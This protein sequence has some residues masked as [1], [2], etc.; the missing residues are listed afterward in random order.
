MVIQGVIRPPPEI[1]AVADR[2]ALYVAKNG[3]AFETRILNSDKGRTPKFAFLSPSSPF[4]AYYEDKVQFYESGGEDKKEEGDGEGK[5]KK[6]EG[7]GEKTT[8]KKKKDD[9]ATA[10]AKKTGTV[11]AIDPVAKIVLSQRTKIAHL[12]AEQEKKAGKKPSD[13]NDDEGDEE[14]KLAAVVS[15]PAPPQLQF[16]NIVAPSSLGAAQIEK[17]Q[18]VA[19]LTALD[20]SNKGRLGGPA[21]SPPSS[22]SFLSQLSRREWNNPSF[23]F[24]QPRHGHFA[25]FSSLVD[26]YR[27]IIERW[28]KPPRKEKGSAGN[29]NDDDDDDS[30][31]DELANNVQKCLEVAA[32]RAEYD[33]DMDEQATKK[34]EAMAGIAQ[35]DWHDFV[36]VETIDFPVDEVVE[37]SMMPPPAAESQPP[38]SSAAA[39]T[40]AAAKATEE[41]EEEEEEDGEQIRVVPSYQPKIVSGVSTLETV[42]DP[43]TGKSIPVKDMPEHMRIQLLDPKWAEERKKFQDKQKDSNLVAGDIVASNLQRLAQA[44]ESEYATHNLL[45][46]EADPRKRLEEANRI[47]RD[48]AQQQGAVG[49]A[50]PSA[51]AKPP[52]VMAG[53]S[54]AATAGTVR[55]APSS[56]TEPVA[57]RPKIEVTTVEAPPKPGQMS[58]GGQQVSPEAA[59]EDPF[60]S[61]ATASGVTA[62]IMSTSPKETES[63]PILPEAE[64][65]ASL[66]KPEVTLHVRIPNDRAQMAWNF[67]GQTVTHTADVMSKIKSIK[68]E[69]S[70][71]HLNSMPV[72]KIQL[73]DASTKTFYNKDNM[74][75]A[76]LNLGPTATLELLPK[77]RG[78]RR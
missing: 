43:I 63:T 2:T 13:G 11:S 26:A 7:D 38:T 70:K 73:R 9:A 6:E 1:R 69:L 60:A 21:S 75:L 34:D 50:L 64:F 51:S 54:A 14:M 48:Q 77:T 8:T 68:Q 25:Y 10:K 55:P 44:R 31:I 41:E 37:V 5:K 29:S 32:Y 24:C 4:H 57:K 20:A 59:A 18:L 33:R 12:R 22:S 28:K 67:Y 42:I 74:T 78:G 36:V 62:D 71:T 47:I 49:P 27:Y 76:A 23:A 58:G 52:P 61:A 56:A 40:A 19:Q 16:V 66:E 39:A 35:I 46:K 65:A 15:L 45:S 3:R 17:I 53:A 30:G 72:N